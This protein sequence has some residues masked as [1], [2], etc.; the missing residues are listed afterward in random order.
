MLVR[1]R[2]T[3]RSPCAQPS[4]GGVVCGHP[5][6]LLSFFFLPHFSTLMWDRITVLVELRPDLSLPAPLSAAAE[7]DDLGTRV[8]DRSAQPL[9]NALHAQ[10]GHAQE[11]EGD[12]ALGAPAEEPGALLEEGEH[13]ISNKTIWASMASCIDQYFGYGARAAEGPSAASQLS[14]VLSGRGGP[15]VVHHWN[16]PV[17]DLKDLLSTVELARA[18]GGTFFSVIGFTIKHIRVE[19][20]QKLVAVPALSGARLKVVTILFDPVGENG[21]NPFRYT[22]PNGAVWDIREALT[23]AL[24]EPGVPF[25]RLHLEII[26]VVADEAAPRRGDVFSLEMLPRVSVSVYHVPIGKLPLVA[27][28]LAQKHF[29]LSSISVNFEV[30]FLSQCPSCTLPP[31]NTVFL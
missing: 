26:R 19:V 16:S 20:E 8:N 4:A 10:P 22:E 2:R 25:R 23:V 7:A 6:E 18:D 9:P 12:Q 11:G 1:A 3:R 14:L 27:R 17:A 13:E 5:L 29:E 31:M 28:N 15:S 21:S 24:K 30:A